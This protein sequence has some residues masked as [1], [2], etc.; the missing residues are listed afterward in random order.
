MKNDRTNQ[1]KYVPTTNTNGTER[2]RVRS[3]MLISMSHLTQDHKKHYIVPF[4]SSFYLVEGLK[5]VDC[6][7][8]VPTYAHWGTSRKHTVP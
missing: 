3:K 7:L 1:W 6:K 4:N 5:Y 2:R 8:Y